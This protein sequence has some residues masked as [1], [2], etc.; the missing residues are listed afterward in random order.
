VQH[1]DYTTYNPGNGVCR[2][3]NLIDSQYI[4]GRAPGDTAGDKGTYLPSNIISGKPIGKALDDFLE[5]TCGFKT[6]F[7]RI[8][9]KLEYGFIRDKITIDPSKESIMSTEKMDDENALPYKP[10]IVVVWSSDGHT[11]EYWP[12]A[13]FADGKITIMNFKLSSNNFAGSLEAFAERIYNDAQ[14]NTDIFKVRFPPGTTR[15]KEGDWFSGLGDQT[16][17][18]PM[19]YKTGEDLNPLVEPGDTVWRITD[20]VITEAGTDIV[21]GP[22]YYSIFDLYKTSLSPVD[23]VP[24]TTETINKHSSVYITQKTATT[25]GV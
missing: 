7:D 25:T 15:F 1:P 17:T 4:P 14:V 24:T 5:N 11:K 10:N 18:H 2:A 6:W 9:G 23:S 8:N 19:E 3:G 21:V 12:K 16:I 20:V 22:S 13:A